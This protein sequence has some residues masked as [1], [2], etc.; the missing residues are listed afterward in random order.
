MVGEIRNYDL[1]CLVI[2]YSIDWEWLI[3]FLKLVI[4]PVSV[5]CTPLVYWIWNQIFFR[6]LQALY[7]GRI[8]VPAYTNFH[9]ENLENWP[10]FL[11]CLIFSW[12]D[13][14]PQV[15]FPYHVVHVDLLKIILGISI[16]GL[17]LQRP[18][19]YLTCHKI[20]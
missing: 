3:K 17:Y 16:N 8:Y 4:S 19:F 14:K 6:Q 11:F 20:F 15:S 13:P 12:P 9:H 2:R 18:D 5:L 10:Y 1:S 7:Q